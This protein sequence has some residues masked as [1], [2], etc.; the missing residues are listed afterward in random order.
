MKRFSIAIALLLAC[1]WAAFPLAG[2]Q[3]LH[4]LVVDPQHYHLQFE[5]Q[6][7]KIIR[8]RIPPHDK[9]KTTITRSVR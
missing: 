4:P 3:S 6:Y 7:V 1:A 2:M 9:V 8:G 5:N